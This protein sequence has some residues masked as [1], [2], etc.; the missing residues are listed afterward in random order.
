[1]KSPNQND[2]IGFACVFYKCETLLNFTMTQAIIRNS[3]NDLT[4]QFQLES[5]DYTV[6]IKVS[7]LRQV[8]IKAI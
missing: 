5:F 2:K 6:T 1:M 8:K 7:D 4:F 3:N